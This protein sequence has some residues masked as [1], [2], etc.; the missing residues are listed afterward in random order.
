MSK[1]KLSKYVW[2][3]TIDD[4]TLDEDMNSTVGVYESEESAK[5]AWKELDTDEDKPEYVKYYIDEVP[6]F[7]D[8][9]LYSQ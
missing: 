3:I 2:V 7:L 9:I 5:A 1:L 8:Y 4:P 6:M